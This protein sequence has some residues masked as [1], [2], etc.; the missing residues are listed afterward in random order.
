M[1]DLDPTIHQPARL[2][3]L[4]ILSG[5]DS[6][7]FTFLQQTLG[8]SKGNLSTH[9]ARLEEKGYVKVTKSFRGTM[10]HTSYRLTKLGRTDLG[11]YWEAVDAIRTHG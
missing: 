4:M 9:M 2:R 1:R 5:A 7:D 8:L 10:P 6:A 3:I 11:A